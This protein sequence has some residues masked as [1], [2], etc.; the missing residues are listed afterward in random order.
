MPNPLYTYILNIYDL[1]WLSFMAYQSM[2][3]YLMQD[4]IF[5]FVSNIKYMISKHILLIH[6]VKWLN[7]SISNNSIKQEST[8]L[9]GS[10]Y[11]YE[12]LAIQLNISHLFT[13][14]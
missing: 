8:K 14:S 9:N 10:K 2:V 4:P 5:T 6:T 3:G 12:S 13:H 1:V 11:S 7:S